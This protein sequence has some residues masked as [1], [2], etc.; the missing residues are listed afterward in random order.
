MEN[1][2]LNQKRYTVTVTDG[3]SLIYF[4][5]AKVDIINNSYTYYDNIYVF[6]ILVIQFVK[7]CTV[8]LVIIY[9]S[10]TRQWKKDVHNEHI[11]LYVIMQL[12]VFFSV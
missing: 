11:Y 5:H 8:I 12:T 4:M 10:C 7:R 9:I 2:I 1:V 3:D 6:I